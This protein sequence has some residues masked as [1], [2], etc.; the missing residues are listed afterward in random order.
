[1]ASSICRRV[2][3][4]AFAELAVQS[5]KPLRRIRRIG[6]DGFWHVDR[7]SPLS[8]PERQDPRWH[9]ERTSSAS[10]HRGESNL[11]SSTVSDGEMKVPAKRSAFREMAAARSFAEEIPAA[12]VVTRFSVRAM[13]ERSISK[14]V[15]E[16]SSPGPLQCRYDHGTVISPGSK[17]SAGS[18]L[19]RLNA[20]PL[21]MACIAVPTSMGECVEAFEG[22]SPMI[23]WAA[24]N[25]VA[26]FNR[27]SR[28]RDDE[29]PRWSRQID[30]QTSFD[31][32]SRPLLSSSASHADHVVGDFQI[33]VRRASFHKKI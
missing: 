17:R 5:S 6:C 15:S 7:R 31:S 8:L 11:K 26:M 29:R 25:P 23:S 27:Q 33:G 1:M 13:R 12:T 30:E 16:L 10:D 22:R 24:G 21:P 19:K 18:G 32:Y 9:V 14:L 4:K 28:K 2:C 20:R 3:L